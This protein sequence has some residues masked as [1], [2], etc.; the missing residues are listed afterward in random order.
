MGPRFFGV[1][2]SPAPTRGPQQPQRTVAANDDWDDPSPSG[3]GSY[4]PN[5]LRRL[6]EFC[7]RE[8]WQDYCA[9][10]APFG[11]SKDGFLL[12]IQYEARTTVN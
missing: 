9:A 6:L 3:E 8:A 4:D 10:G 1:S 5:D 11:R 12:W 2:I 7:W